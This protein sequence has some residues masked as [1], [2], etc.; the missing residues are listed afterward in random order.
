M[1]WAQLLTSTIQLLC[2]SIPEALLHVTMKRRAEYLLKY[3]SPFV[4]FGLI[5]QQFHNSKGHFYDK[6]HSGEVFISCH[7]S[8]GGGALIQIEVFI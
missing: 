1:F 2:T 3:C 5:L 4:V 8:E 7:L 6:R